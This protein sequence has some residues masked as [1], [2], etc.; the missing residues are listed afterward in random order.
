[1][2]PKEQELLSDIYQYYLETGRRTCGIRFSSPKEK[3]ELYTAL[4]NLCDDGYIEYIAAAT[5]MCDFKI[6][7][8]GI[9]FAKNGYQEPSISP[10]IQ[11]A[12]S[13]FINGS[14]NNVSNNYNQISID[15]ANSDIP[16][17][18]K[19][20][21]NAFILEMQSSDLSPEKKSSKIRSFLTDISSGTLSGIA[22]SGLT[23]LLSS[24]LNLI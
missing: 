2:N 16:D 11:G 10:I 15:I 17:E 18:C 12:N 14:G 22:S 7:P 21:I 9:N 23:A 8:L 3:S 20:L 24:L 6:T 13:I 4:D 1:M 19:Q 5:G